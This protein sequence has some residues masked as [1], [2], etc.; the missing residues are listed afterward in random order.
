V[1]RRI[2]PFAFLGLTAVMVVAE[3]W[4]AADGS[5][6]TVPWT[7]YLMRFVPEEAVYALIGALVLWLPFH[8]WR[9]YRRRQQ[10]KRDT[11]T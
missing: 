2:W 11:T 3:V 9:R 8:F 7:D 5:P 4:A 10:A 1:I 6:N